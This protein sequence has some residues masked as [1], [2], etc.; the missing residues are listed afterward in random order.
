MNLNLKQNSNMTLSDL[1]ALANKF[2]YVIARVTDNSITLHK[3]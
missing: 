2:S 3:E 1:I